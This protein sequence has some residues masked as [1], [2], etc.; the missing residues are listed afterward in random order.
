MVQARR[1]Q[2][3]EAAGRGSGLVEMEWRN[4]TPHCVIW[5][6]ATPTDAAITGSDVR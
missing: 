3:P 4:W 2:V 6:P 1:K 5:Y